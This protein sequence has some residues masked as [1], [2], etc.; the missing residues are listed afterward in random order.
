LKEKYALSDR[1]NERK[2]VCVREK[3][4]KREREGGKNKAKIASCHVR[5]TKITLV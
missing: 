5:V 3:E 2:I 1:T 4:R